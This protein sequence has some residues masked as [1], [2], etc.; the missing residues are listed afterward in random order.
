MLA[1]LRFRRFRSQLLC[2]LLLGLGASLGVFMLVTRQATEAHALE[3]VRA[4]F[5]EAARI[6]RRLVE[7]KAGPLSQN[8]QIFAHDY[9]FIQ[10]YRNNHEGTIRSALV[11]A[12]D[13][14]RANHMALVDLDGRTQVDV[15]ASGHPGDASPYAPLIRRATDQD[16]EFDFDYGYLGNQFSILVVVPIRVGEQAVAWIG[17]AETI[18]AEIAADLK[19]LSRVEVTFLRP[20]RNLVISTL[21]AAVQPA[22]AREFAG[23]PPSR[24]PLTATLTL[25]GE[26]LLTQRFDLPGAD[27]SHTT[28]VLAYSLDEKLASSRALQRLL[29]GIGLGLLALGAIVGLGV[30]R[31]VSEPVR[32]LAEHTAVIAAGDYETRLSL[33]RVDELG[34]LAE[35]F[36]AMSAGLA[37][38]DR[39][40]D[41]LDKNVSPAVAAQLLRD[42]AALGGEEREV[43]IL[44]ADLRG[45]TTLSEK[46]PPRELLALLNRYLDRMS[47]AIEAQGGVIDKFIGDAIMALFGAPV[48]QDDA[49]DRA[50]AAA[51]AMEAALAALNAELAAEGRPPLALGIGV[52]TARVVAGNIGSHRRLNYSVIGDGVNVAARLQSLTRTAEYRTNI[53]TSA[54]TL[55]AAKGR[56]VAA[57]PLGPVTVKGRAGAVEIFAISAPG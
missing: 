11:S 17:V 48:G 1:P 45:F 14:C 29:L 7:D 4:D 25:G 39:V 22:V 51:L 47:A 52:N 19:D 24:E 50:L 12:R 26:R 43:T 28:V 57:R 41:L 32:R 30:A 21:P 38:R 53:I 2:V 9:S 8:A 54:A 18:D 44:F 10:A 40:R 42:G 35:S 20:E 37:E 49:A 15:E 34:Q 31:G 23:L 56:R 3:E 27:G 13:R 55:A 33:E 46:L 36:N 5:D 6:L 16:K